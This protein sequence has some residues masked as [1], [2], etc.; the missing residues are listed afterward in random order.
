MRI[1]PKGTVA[2]Y[3]ALTVRQ[4]L[5]RLQFYMTWDEADAAKAAALPLSAAKAF[6]VALERAGLAEVASKGRWSITQTGKRLSSATAARP[7][8]R[9]TAERA[10]RE[11]LDRVEEVNRNDYYL[12]RVAAL[13]LFGSML[14]R[15]VD[16]LSDV[17]VAVDVIPKEPDRERARQANY[18]RA[19]ELEAKGH[20][21][22]FP[23]ARAICWKTEVFDFLQHR[24]RVIALADLHAEGELI[25]AVPHKIVYSEPGWTPYIPPPEVEV[26]RTPIP[27]DPDCPF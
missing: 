7:I 23:P 1:D 6:A 21:F 11:F 20:T 9:A 24:S 17:D 27:D 22:R 4:A 8:L 18:G 19:S 14:R 5:R 25:L 13:V 2:G 26:P 12:G 16:R 10:Y 3:P 15:E